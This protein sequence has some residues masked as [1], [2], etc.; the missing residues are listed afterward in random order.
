MLSIPIFIP[1]RKTAPTSCRTMSR[2]RSAIWTKTAV[3]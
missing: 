3:I 1:H 2:V